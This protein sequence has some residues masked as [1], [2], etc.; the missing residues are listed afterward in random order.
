M[1]FL[2]ESEMSRRAFFRLAAVLANHEKKEATPQPFNSEI[3]TFHEVPS[4]DFIKRALSGYLNRNIQ[5][6]SIIDIARHFRGEETLPSTGTALITLDDGL[7]SQ[8]NAIQAQKELGVQL[9]L[10]FAV[11]ANFNGEKMDNTAPSE[12][13]YSDGNHTYLSRQ[14]LQEIVGMGYDLANHTYNHARLPEQTSEGLRDQLDFCRQKIDW[15]Y[16]SVGRGGQFWHRTVVFP[17]G[18]YNQRVIDEVAR[19][20]SVVAFSTEDSSYHSVATQYHLGRSRTGK[21]S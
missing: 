9:P 10:L 5:F 21:F 4:V 18:R 19:Q 12:P 13:S 1:S 7:A 15:I 20:G 3:L 8:L 11:I 6:L 17:E 14:Q 2:M 16:E